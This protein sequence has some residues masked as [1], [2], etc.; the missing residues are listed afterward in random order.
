MTI[1]D[2]IIVQQTPS[3]RERLSLRLVQAGA[4]AA[5]L[6]VAALHT[7]ELD[8]FFVPKELVL[9]LTAMLAGALAIKALTRLEITMVD[10]LLAI[11]I[12]LSLASAVL[13]TNRWLGERALAISISS[14]VIFWIARA[15]ATRIEASSPELPPVIRHEPRLLLIGLGLAIV[16]ASLTSLLQTYGVDVDFF[17]RNRAPGGTLGNRNFIAHVAAFGWPVL[18]LLAIQAK[19]TSRYLLASA[20][21]AIVTASL[22][23]TRSRAAWLAFAIS[24]VVFLF[25][26]LA[27]RPVRSE[28]R[29]WRRIHGAS[30][31]IVGASAAAIFI[32]NTLDWRSDNPYMES[33]KRVA[34]Y[35][36]G[37]GAGR[38]VQY[39]RSMAMAIHDPLFGAGPGNWP[40]EYPRFAAKGDPSLDDSEP[41]MTSNPWPSSDWIAF[42]SERGVLTTFALGLAL[43][44]LALSSLRRLRSAAT[45]DEGLEA[46][47][48]LAVLSAAIVAGLF[49]AVLL[50]AVPALIVWGALG[51]LWVPDRSATVTLKFGWRRFIA[52]LLVLACG[53]A[54]AR[55][56]GQL[57]AMQL[58]AT[59]SGRA[60]LLRAATLDPGN[61][62]LQLRLARSGNRKER[63]GHARAAASLFPNAAAARQ[64]VRGCR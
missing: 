41:G 56:A 46:A 44:L 30:L 10:L 38:L 4:I 42:L 29:N 7:F 6:V 2:P 22:V 61:Y 28:W 13:A 17:S 63:C 15:L 27:S 26:L 23:L 5:V 39:Q 34:D 53:A 64:A 24:A 40:V 11:W 45:R 33:V 3:R 50:L 19:R 57:A 36:G 62:R 49:D 31:L 52:V 59:G 20:G 51:A 16:V 25:A 55:S 60:S 48:L 47:A 1:T 32:P 14:V 37:S 12:V 35:Q 9:H 8:R 43:L 54:A 21:L 18:M 58:Y